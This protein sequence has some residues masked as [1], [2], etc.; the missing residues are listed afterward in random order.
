M[1][2]A[3]VLGTLLMADLIGW[4][5]LLRVLGDEAV[6]AATSRYHSI[7]DRAVRCTEA[8][9]SNWS[10]TTHWRSSSGRETQ[11]ESCTGR[12]GGGPARPV[13][14]RRAPL[15]PE[16]RIHSARLVSCSLDSL[17][18]GALRNPAVRDRRALAD[19][20]LPRDR[21]ASGGRGLEFQLEDSESGRSPADR[22]DRVFGLS[23]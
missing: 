9:R 17:I 1:S 14:L 16:M 6:L 23:I 15:R 2:G 3:N 8:A 21:S 4:S 10:V 22:P 18:R 7:I 13:D 19:P 20:R 12:P 5:T 11:W